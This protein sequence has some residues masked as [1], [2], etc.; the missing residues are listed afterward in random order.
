[1]QFFSLAYVPCDRRLRKTAWVTPRLYGVGVYIGVLPSGGRVCCVYSRLWPPLP[2]DVRASSDVIVVPACGR[3]R[4][5]RGVVHTIFTL[6]RNFRVLIVRS[7]SPSKATTVMGA[8]RRRFPR[9]LFVI[10]H[11]KGLKLKAT[12][13]TNFG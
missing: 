9:H 6:G 2:V 1:M 7:N 5:V 10:R 3:Q 13:V 8:L 11:G 12:C 4:G